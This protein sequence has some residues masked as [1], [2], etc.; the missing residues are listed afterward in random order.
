[1]RDPRRPATRA[2]LGAGLCVLLAAGATVTAACSEGGES[3]TVDTSAAAPATSPAAGASTTTT[4]T[5]PVATNTI[6]ADDF[7][8]APSSITV[9]TGT[10]VTWKNADN[11]AHAISDDGGGFNGSAIAAGASFTHTYTGAGTFPFHCSI[12]PSMTG[13]VTVSG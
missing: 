4:A 10:A 6:T 2:R 9:K 8:F 13:T 12:H 1:M 11:V 7:A 3:P 5:G